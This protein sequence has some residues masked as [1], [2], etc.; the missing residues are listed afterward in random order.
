VTRNGKIKAQP[1]AKNG[2]KVVVFSIHNRSH[3][4]YVHRLLAEAFIPKPDYPCEVR[5]LNGIRSDNRLENLMWGSRSEN[6]QDAIKH[7]TATVG[8]KNACAKLRESD[9][10]FIK[11][12]KFMGFK[13]TEISKYFSVTPQTISR[14]LTNQTYRNSNEQ[15]TI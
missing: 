5:H 2:Y 7:G 9:V 14:L 12:M 4:R 13:A 8:H 10:G 15:P 6:M 3:T 1:V 11:D